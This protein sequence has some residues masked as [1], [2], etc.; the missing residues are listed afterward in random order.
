MS[1]AIVGPSESLG[2]RPRRGGGGARDTAVSIA[3]GVARITGLGSGGGEG[4]GGAEAR[5]ATASG[6]IISAMMSA[7][8]S[9]TARHDSVPIVR[10]PVVVPMRVSIVPLHWRSCLRS[11]RALT[12]RWR[13]SGRR[14][15][16]PNRFRIEASTSDVVGHSA[17][18]DQAI[19]TVPASARAGAGHSATATPAAIQT[20]ERHS[21]PPRRSIRD[22][23][24]TAAFGLR[25]IS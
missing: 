23:N 19:S 9:A 1:T 10:I 7:V 5:A 15:D 8:A 3:D 18:A 16:R 2:A 13:P 24:V 11:A 4:I 6:S 22:R 12:S 21:P 17:G 14:G 25:A 20:L